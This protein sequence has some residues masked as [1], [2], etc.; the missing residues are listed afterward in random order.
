MS[1]DPEFYL[2]QYGSGLEVPGI[3][4]VFEYGDASRFAHGGIPGALRLNDRS[5][6]DQIRVTELSGLHDD[7]DVGDSRTDRAG[8]WGERAGLL[9]PRGKTLGLTGHVRAGNV[10]RMRDL[11]RHMRSQFGRAEQDFVIHPPNETTHY[12]NEVWS[13]HLD[14]WS[15]G[16]S[17][18]TIS[19]FTTFTDIFMNGLSETATMTGAGALQI[20]GATV[21]DAHGNPGGGLMAPW[22]GEDVW[23]TAIVRPHAAAATVTSISLAVMS[24]YYDPL[25][26]DQTVVAVTPMTGTGTIASP[27]TG[28]YYLLYG[29]M[30][31][32]TTPFPRTNFVL[33]AVVMNTPATTGTYTLR[34]GRLALALLDSS[35]DSPAGF[36]D[37]TI[38]GFEWVGA[39]GKSVGPGYSVNQAHD[40]LGET[41]SGWGDASTFG[42]VA[43]IAGA[44]TY[45]WPGEGKTSSAWTLRNPNT[46]TRTLAIR[47][48]VALAD[49]DLFVVAS[50]RSYRAHVRLRVLESYTAGALRV[51]WLNQS[52]SVLATSVID[53]FPAVASGGVA[54]ELELDG[55][56]VAPALAY[57]AYMTLSP[58]SPTAT[59]GAR[60]SLLVTESCFVDVSD[61]DPGSDV[62]INAAQ[63]PELGIG[64]YTPSIS[65][66]RLELKPNGARRRIPRPFLLRHVRALWDGKAPESQRNLLARRDFTMSLRAADPRIYAIDERHALLKMPGSPTFVIVNMSD[67]GITLNSAAP[68]V[69]FDNF[70]GTTAG[71]ALNGRTAPL[72]GAWA[73]SGDTTDFTFTDTPQEGVERFTTT[74]TNGRT[75]LLGTTAYTETDASA[76]VSSI[77]S[78]IDSNIG[79]L[80]RYV[81]AS[82]YVRA[83]LKVSGAL[84]GGAFVTVSI[85]VA[86]SPTILDGGVFSHTPGTLYTLRVILTSG[87]GMLA[88]LS[89]G[90][91]VVSSVSTV[92]SRLA[93]GG[94]LASGRVGLRDAASGSPTRRF[95]D[96]VSMKTPPNK[97]LAPTGFT[98]Y[99]TSLEQ[100]VIW[101]TSSL[102]ASFPRGGITL[103]WD[104]AFP[105][106]SGYLA[107]DSVARMYYSAGATYLT[108]RTTVSGNV[109]TGNGYDYDLFADSLISGEW[110][111]NTLGAV[112]KRVS[113]STWIEARFN[114]ANSVA[115]NAANPTPAAPFSLELWSSHTTAGSSGETRLGGWDVPTSEIISGALK[116]VRTYMDS[117]NIVYVELWNKDPNVIDDGLILRKT[118][119]LPAPLVTLYGAGVAGQAGALVKLARWSNGISS[120][121]DVGTMQINYD[122]P[123]ISGFNASEYVTTLVDCPVIGDVD[124][125]PLRLELRGDLDSPIVTRINTETGESATLMLSGTFLESDPVTI[126]MDVGTIKSASGAN[127]FS[128]RI[129]GSRFFSLAP[130][131]NVL[132]LQAAS[133]D[134]D[135]PVHMIASWR[136]A[137]K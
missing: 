65:A 78:D 102:S 51:T 60:L 40:T 106:A 84:L 61:Y 46:T 15:A 112:L 137:L 103:G 39:P 128:R 11:W 113:L 116:H 80:T 14:N 124:D 20:L 97:T 56:A 98:Y 93:T 9:V 74:F 131:H 130:G 81:D 118:Y 111:Y 42:A 1:V 87:G 38:P 12:M 36:F 8:H 134:A 94:V 85:V 17:G 88:T 47:A 129:A 58:N 33:P 89:S 24:L 53:I 7:P 123:Y 62:E 13:D 105:P 76:V 86:G 107:V 75:A 31:P 57:R 120:G 5:M 72:G 45:S 92:D 66:G 73:T 54:Q 29:R 44:T 71:N 95:Y 100:T 132:A 109:I 83:D 115:M 126:D 63:P 79:L 136:D 135:A 104:E 122:T 119:T 114:S 70:T 22:T 32:S 10:P 27:G 21:L 82:N 43:D 52:N 68:Q 117:S 6:P 133:W 23:M 18:G 108:P 125:V 19:S 69:A 59:N 2:Y 4:A 64:T 110:Q 41:T 90:S 28:A 99:N 3:E 50:G 30:S 49:P 34:I 35:E 127:Y 101:R 48:S 91:T 55:V 121:I 37:G 26:L 67:Y 25:H 77:Q 16:V 96:S